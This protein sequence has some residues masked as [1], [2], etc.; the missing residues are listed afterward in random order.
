MLRKPYSRVRR[1]FLLQALSAVGFGSAVAAARRVLAQ[2][3]QLP[4]IYSVEG[5]VRLNGV[6]A[7]P[8]FLV[9][10]GDVVETGARSQ[11][12][13]VAGAD[14]FLVRAATRLQTSGSEG[15]ISA[16]RIVTGK[17]LSVFGP[18]ERRI[19]TETATI[20]IRG[21]GIYVEAEQ[22]RTYVCTCY[23]VADLQPR[24]E[25][26]LLETVATR[27]HEQPRYIY[28]SRS[29]PANQ[30]M[31]SAPVI[32]HTDA[33]LVLLESLVGRSPPFLGSGGPP[34]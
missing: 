16:L 19:E 24:D 11:A 27:H 8:G 28:S 22:E 18:G 21:T 9:N 25:P 7:A 32:D 33:E 13:F 10:P 29:M 20:G 5:E 4:G 6:P 3:A 15:F 34:Y 17:V 23:G 31:E 30:M 14:A 12:V 1:R 26:Q 2:G